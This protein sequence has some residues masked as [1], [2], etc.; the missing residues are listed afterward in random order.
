MNGNFVRF[1][2]WALPAA[3]ILIL[4]PW[5]V[6][7]SAPNASSDPDGYARQL[8]SGPSVAAGYVYLVGLLCLLFGLLALYASLPP[9]PGSLPTVGMVLSLSSV[10]LLLPG[11]G[12]LVIAGPVLGDV[13]LAGHKDVSL[14]M[15]ALAGG[16]FTGRII[17]YF[18]VVMLVAALGAIATGTNLW[19][20]RALPRWMIVALELG[21]ILTIVSAPIVTHVGAILLIITGVWIARRLAQPVAR[22]GMAGA[23][24][25]P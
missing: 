12:V 6:F 8:T 16:S 9:A 24:A 22:L 1:G 18:V 17:A 19:R 4:L 14:A 25:A 10:A 13:Y 23:R 7:L 2:I 5:F 3:G 20:T 11:F 21:F 15:V